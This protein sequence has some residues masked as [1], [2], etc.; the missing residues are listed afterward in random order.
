MNLKKIIS[1]VSAVAVAAAMLTACGSTDVQVPTSS[2]YVYNSLSD[3][4]RTA[5]N[6]I[7]SGVTDYKHSVKIS[8][9]SEDEFNDFILKFYCC[10][11]E[12]FYMSDQ[13]KYQINADGRVNECFFTYDYYENST[14]SMQEQLDAKADEILSKITS[15]MTDADKLKY[16]HD[17]IIDNVTYDAEAMD[18]DN[19]YGALIKNRTHCQGF[20][21][22]ICFLCD[23]LG[24][25]SLLITGD[26]GGGHMWNMVKIDDKWYHL[27]A[28]WDDPDHGGRSRSDYFLISDSTISQTHTAD[29]YMDYPNASAD[30]N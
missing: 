18:C 19:V 14:K 4:E 23:K 15:D 20:S 25:E 17:Y 12:L 22:S 27:D 28:T 13:I 30:Y 26:A 10:G 5:F 2:Q 3:K 9:M 16:I 21:K 29:T 7:Y 1:A 8:S 6:K 11:S 24:I